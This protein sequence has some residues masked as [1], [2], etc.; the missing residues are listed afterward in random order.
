MILIDTSG[1]LAL[2]ENSN[3]YRDRVM[4]IISNSRARLLSPFV[5]A[6][7]DYLIT[8]DAGAHHA[9]TLLADIERGVY[10]LEPFRGE[11][12]SRAREIMEKYSDLNIGLADASIVVLS[13]RHDCTD[14]LT[15]DQRHFRAVMP[16]IG[17]LFR[18]LLL[19]DQ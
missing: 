5:L 10:S 15:S 16:A 18:L 3:P 17:K 8:R 6:E 19:D 7:L 13:E 14:I 4:R 11:D 1:L 2:H 12:I 9:R